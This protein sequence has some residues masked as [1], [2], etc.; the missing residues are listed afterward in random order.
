[1]LLAARRRTIEVWAS[2]GISWWSEGNSTIT[3]TI[4]SPAW[5]SLESMADCIDGVVRDQAELHGHLRR[6][7]ALGLTLLS[8]RDVDESFT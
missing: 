6:V 7:A 3:L 5:N 2:A 8:V 4:P 1:M